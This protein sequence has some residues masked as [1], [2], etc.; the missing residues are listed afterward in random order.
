[1]AGTK[2]RRRDLPE[3]RRACI[4]NAARCV[5]ARQGYSDTVVEDIADH[6]GIGKGTLYLYFRSKE[7]IFVA[8]LIEDG[9]KMEQATRERMDAAGTWQ[10]KLRAYMD[11]RLEYLETHQDFL[12][13]FL[14]EVRGMMVRGARMNAELFQCIRE[15]V[16][17]LT[18]VFAVAVAR[19]EIRPV[20]PEMAALTMSD[21]M[22][23]LMERRLL[24]WSNATGSADALFA[25]DL[26]CRGLELEGRPQAAPH[27]ATG[28]E[29]PPN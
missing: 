9:R 5:F 21:L 27:S 23:G 20:D 19:D 7:D 24:G 13:I 18:Q 10:E 17:H 26:F 29:Y 28:G 16:G 8:A 4:L 12:R 25:L 2:P 6:A 15:S 11:V 3:N 14:A 22:K 1:M